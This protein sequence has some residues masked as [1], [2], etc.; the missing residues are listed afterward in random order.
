MLQRRP[1]RPAPRTRTLAVGGALAALAVIGGG[2]VMA[3]SDPT[4]VPSGDIQLVQNTAAQEMELGAPVELDLEPVIARA[5]GGTIPEGTTVQVTG[6]PDGLN[7]DGWVIAGTPTRAGTYDVL[8]TVSNGA[9]SQSETVSITVTET[10]GAGTGNEAGAATADGAGEDDEATTN[11]STASEP[12]T[13][14]PEPTLSAVPGAM[15]AQDEGAGTAAGPGADEGTAEGAGDGTAASPDLCAIARD[16]DVDGASLANGLAPM[17]SG[18]GEAAPSGLAMVL[19]NAVAGLLPS[20]LGESGSAADAGS[21]GE[22]LCTLEPEITGGG[23]AAT[24]TTGGETGSGTDLAG[25]SAALLGLLGV[26][27]GGVGG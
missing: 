16:G 26:G 11:H 20:L 22:V 25:A 5:A 1:L 17:I 12:T 23:D 19:V 13:Q 21:F 15:T 27:A 4:D 9:V 6:L 7:Q 14:Q 10:Q 2:T 8:I 3:V 24:A 18:D